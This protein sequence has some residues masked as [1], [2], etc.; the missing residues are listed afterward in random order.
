LT[1]TSKK[2]AA[3]LST[4]GI[5]IVFLPFALSMCA[6]LRGTQPESSHPFTHDTVTVADG[7]RIAYHV[8]EASGPV[9]ML[10]PG[11]WGDYRVFD[12]L[13]KGLDPKF[14]VVIVEMRG[15]GGSWPPTMNGSIEMFADDV[16]AVV[17]HLQLNRW[18]VG[19]H[20]IGGMIAIEIAGRNPPGL[21]GAISME[22]WTN[23]R[24]QGEAFGN[25]DAP[26]L[27]PEQAVEREKTHARV[28]DRL[29]EEQRKSFG[30]IW[31]QW[32]GT[33]ALETTAVPVLEIWGDRAR[34]RPSRELL[35]IPDRDT[36]KLVW[37]AGT[38]HTYLIE[39]PGEVASAINAFMAEQT[40][41]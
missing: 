5:A 24:V 12:E 23:Y 39:R 22:G 6:S 19:G 8:R 26:T 28:K 16:L 21:A 13:L 38:S 4:R 3:R 14:R 25:T 36:I 9:L 34:P 1:K 40:V 30:S 20:S 17:E 11:S 27:S 41:K 2:V 15:H 35:Q 37:I 29:T 32:D 10:I 18:S 33:R 31:R 7:S